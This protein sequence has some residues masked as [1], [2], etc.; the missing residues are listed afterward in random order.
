MDEYTSAVNAPES[1]VQEKPFEREFLLSWIKWWNGRRE[2]IF[3]AFTPA[4]PRMN[5]AEVVH[6]SWAHRDKSNLSL[7]DAA[8]M[9]TRDSLLLEG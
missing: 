2:F 1:F 3:N 4:G 7:L 8:R 6:A 9:D 5:Q